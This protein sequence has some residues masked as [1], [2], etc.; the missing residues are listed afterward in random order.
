MPGTNREAE[1]RYV[2]ADVR[3]LRNAL[4][5]L[6]PPVPRPVLV[7]VSGLPGTG[8]SYFSRRLVERVPLVVVDSALMRKTL[9]PR[10]T[11][12]PE[13]SRRLFAAVHALVA[14][15]LSEGVPVVVDATTLTEAHRSA[16]HRVAE[17]AGAGLVL[18]GVEAPPEVAYRR[19]ERRRM[20][21]RPEDHSQADWCVY[22]K[23]A[24]T[25]EP[26]SRDHIIVNTAGDI[27]ADLERVSAEVG[28]L[29]RCEA[30]GCDDYAKGKEAT[31]ISR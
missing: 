1:P 27:S 25:V 29:M 22:R 10:R 8:K 3:R 17:G 14:E 26:I 6:R 2:A 21:R 13:E 11:Y 23:M 31:W 4:G 7:A 30:S 24:P 20:D 9:S 15:L 19:L 16:L 5:G 18:V 12:S 28:R